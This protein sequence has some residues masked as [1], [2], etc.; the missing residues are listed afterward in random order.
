MQNLLRNYDQSEVTADDYIRELRKYAQSHV[1]EGKP[2]ISEVLRDPFVR[3]MCGS[4]HY[5]HSTFCD[6]VITGL[7]GIVPRSDNVL[8]VHPLVPETWDYFCLD[9]ARYR[10]HLVTIVWDRTGARYGFS[11]F[12]VYV[13]KEE[14]YSSDMPSRVQVYL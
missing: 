14:R 13:D 7:A 8:E 11:G 3:E 1:R 2:S 5:N 4:E 12:R 10:G 9:G 6:L